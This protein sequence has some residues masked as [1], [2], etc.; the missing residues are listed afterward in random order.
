MYLLFYVEKTRS[1]TGI[2]IGKY[3]NSE[4]ATM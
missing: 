3:K 2:N 4:A 1:V